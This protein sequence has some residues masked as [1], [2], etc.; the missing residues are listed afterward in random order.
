MQ[1][2]SHFRGATYAKEQQ[3]EARTCKVG[4]T[5]RRSSWRAEAFP[6]AAGRGAASSASRTCCVSEAAHLVSTKPPPAIVR[7]PL[8]PLT[9]P[10][11]AATSTRRPQI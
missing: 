9:S 8:R 10:G 6:A 4:I 1:D 11:A 3:Q 2:K 7:V 5:G